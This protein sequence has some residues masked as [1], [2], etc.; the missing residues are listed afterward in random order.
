MNIRRDQQFTQPIKKPAEAGFSIKAKIFSDR[1]KHL[2]DQGQYPAH[3]DTGHPFQYNEFLIDSRKFAFQ[4]MHVAFIENSVNRDKH[5]NRHREGRR[6]VAIH[7]WIATP[8]SGLAM[9]DW[10]AR[11]LIKSAWRNVSRFM[12]RSIGPFVVSLS[13]H[14]QRQH[15][16]IRPTVPAAAKAPRRVKSLRMPPASALRGVRLLCQKEIDFK[17]ASSSEMAV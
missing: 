8:L 2:H 16:A 5:G 4:L 1:E 13:N 12:K 6:P 9:T 7:Y 3:N 10:A 17:L 14:M 11:A 15:S